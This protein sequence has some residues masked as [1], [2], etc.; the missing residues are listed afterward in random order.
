MTSSN[1]IF[2]QGWI[3][4]DGLDE[5]AG[6]P[7]VSNVKAFRKQFPEDAIVIGV[8]EGSNGTAKDR[9]CLCG[10]RPC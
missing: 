1:R 2:G 6:V 8:V 9:R 7:N 10:L 3:V 5:A 4:Y